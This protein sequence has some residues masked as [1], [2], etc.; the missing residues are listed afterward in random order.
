MARV[1]PILSCLISLLIIAGCDSGLKPPFEDPLPPGAIRG[2]ISYSGEWP[3][4]QSL[5]DLRF[6]PLTKAP[7]TVFD[8][9]ADLENLR[10]SG[11]LQYFV[12]DDTFIVEDVVNGVYV[13]NIIAQQFGNN[14]L[15]DWRPVGI[16]TENDGIIVV[17]GDTTTIHIHVD[18]DNLPP[19]PPE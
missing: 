11:R 1:A 8:I 7:Q 5:V 10:F 6:V 19:F 14:I 4:Q 15:A 18:F 2:T 17:N 13:Y 16:Y 12:Q 9:F 3:P